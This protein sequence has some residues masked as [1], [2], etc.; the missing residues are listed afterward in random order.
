MCGRSDSYRNV[1]CCLPSACVD[2]PAQD[3]ATAV[4][5][6]DEFCATF[7][8]SVTLP[9]E[10]NCTKWTKPAVPPD[11]SDS[12]VAGP[13]PEDK[14]TIG[15]A[16]GGGIGGAA[17]IAVGGILIWRRQ[18]RR[19][20]RE[21]AAEAAAQ[22]EG[23]MPELG[24]KEHVPERHELNVAREPGEL[25]ELADTYIPV[26]MEAGGVGARHELHGTPVATSGMSELPV[27]NHDPKGTLQ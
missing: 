15:G 19:E 10:N 11:P 5:F 26:E 9:R 13:V 6:L 20:Q 7:N 14:A 24:G 2:A 17:L 12:A 22:G 21:L 27:H 23:R 3:T 25:R 8:H 4:A 16:L 18:R 1:V